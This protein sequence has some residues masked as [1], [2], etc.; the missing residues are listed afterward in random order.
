MVKLP[1]KPGCCKCI[2]PFYL[3]VIW[4]WKLCNEIKIKKVCVV[5]T[6]AAALCP[7]VQHTVGESQCVTDTISSTLIR[8]VP[9]PRVSMATKASVA[10][11]CERQCGGSSIQMEHA[12]LGVNLLS[13]LVNKGCFL[14]S[15][16]FFSLSEYFITH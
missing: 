15:F 5:I 10:V 16:F 13:G 3:F 7:G 1:C 9:K 12:V 4:P 14:F 11:V 2:L 6:A 8:V